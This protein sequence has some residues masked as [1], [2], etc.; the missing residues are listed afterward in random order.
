MLRRLHGQDRPC[1]SLELARETGLPVSSIAYHLRVLQ[2]CRVT[3]PIEGQAALDPAVPGHESAVSEN[4]WLRDQLAATK[5]ED[6]AD[7]PG[8]ARPR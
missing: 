6:E 8:A 5:A 3:K 2:L 1:S 7:R 4:G